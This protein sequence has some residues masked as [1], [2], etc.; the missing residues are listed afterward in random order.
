[1][2]DSGSSFL[3]WLGGIVATIIAGVILW[4][5]T[6]PGSIINKK[7]VPP[8]EVDGYSNPY[9]NQAVDTGK[10]AIK[11]SDINNNSNRPE[12]V[13]KEKKAAVAITGFSVESP[14][15]VGETSSGNFEITNK[16]DTTATGCQLIW[17]LPGLNNSISSDPFNLEPGE[18]IKFSLISNSLPQK[19][20][21][22][23]IAHLNCS[24]T[25]SINDTRPLVV[26]LMMSPKRFN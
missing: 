26:R 10:P 2:S 9:T 17:E 3:K 18:E 16:G 12:S 20:T 7:Q 13:P 4:W 25:E 8:T 15:N 14:I 23:T 21:I 22:N 24:N 5:L 6:G 1:M 11:P 19:G